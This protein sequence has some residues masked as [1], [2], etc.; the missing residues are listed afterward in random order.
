M[1]I[2]NYL[3]TIS[4]C[5]TIAFLFFIIPFILYKKNKLWK[6]NAIIRYTESFIITIGSIA[7]LMHTVVWLKINGILWS[8]LFIFLAKAEA[9]AF[10]P[11]QI[12]ITTNEIKYSHILYPI[13]IQWNTIEKIII[14]P[15]YISIFKKNGR[16]LQFEIT[17][18][19]S[20]AQLIEIN[21]LCAKL[22]VDNAK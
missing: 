22:I 10:K 4:I 21:E 13:V 15:D 20:D 17:D 5:I 7:L 19:L 3:Y 16:Y 8:I 14:R 9:S 12:T 2:D 18:D 11:Q 6:W 1:A